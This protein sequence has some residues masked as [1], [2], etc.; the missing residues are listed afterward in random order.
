MLLGSGEDAE[1]ADL[2]TSRTS[3]KLGSISL[4]Y[5]DDGVGLM[6]ASLS[7]KYYSLCES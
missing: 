5:D 1:Q 6:R 4:N 3:F 2:M 7:P